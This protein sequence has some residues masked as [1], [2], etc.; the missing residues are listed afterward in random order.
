M[1][2]IIVSRFLDELAKRVLIFDGAMGTMV[3]K[4]HALNL[5]SDFLGRE[6]CIDI[7]TKTRP[8]VLQSI[9]ESFLKA[10][11]DVVETNTFG[12]NKLVL[13]E[14]DLVQEVY[15]LNKQA[16]Q[17]AR[18]ACNRYLSTAKPRFVAGS[19]GPGTKMIS[20]G[21]TNWEN[22]HDS[23]LEQARGLIDGGCDLLIIETCQDLLQAKCAVSACLTALSEKSKTHNDIPIMVSITIETNGTMLLG[24]EI[25]AAV[26]ALHSYPIA[27]L[28]LNCA[29]G[30][31][32]MGEHLAYLAGNWDRNISVI[33]NAGLPTLE[34][35][36]TVYPLLPKPFA[37]TLLRFVNEY[38]VNIVGGCCGTTPEHINE[39]AKLI[40]N[41]TPVKIP[42]E[43][44]KPAISSLYSSIDLKQDTSFLIIGERSNANGSRIFKRLLEA[45][46]WDNLVS[47]GKQQIR[48]GSHML[49]VCVD[50]VGRDGVR[51]ITE[52]ISRYVLQVPVPLM[53]DSTDPAVIEAA[54]KLAGG[55]CLV[56]S[57]NL[58]DGEKRFNE[59]CP[60]LKKYGAGAVALTIDEDPQAGMA[61]TA[62][63]KLEIAQR[64]YNLYTQK[65]QLN[66]ADLLFDPLTFTIA[67]GNVADRRLAL[68]TLEGISSISQYYPECGIVLGVSNVSFGLKP[69][70]RNV[71]NSVFLTEALARGLTAAIVHASKILPRNKIPQNQWDAALN[72]IYDK[73]KTDY[74]PLK[75]FIKLFPDDADDEY[76]REKSA[77]KLDSLT[78]EQ[79]L[80]RHI[81][82]G[83][84]DSLSQ[85]LDAALKIYQP[86]EIIND[87]LLAGM[88]TVGELFGSGKMQLPFVLESAQVMKTAVAYLQPHMNKADQDKAKAKIILATVKGD[89]HDI[90]KNL[91]DIILTNNGY[92]VINLGI[93]QPIAVIINALNEHKAD[94]IGLSGLLVKSVNVM[95]N[96]LHELNARNINV[97][98]LLGGAALTRKYAENHLRQNYH[99]SL[100]YGKDAFEGLR[101]MNALANKTL[102]DIDNEINHRNEKLESLKSS[103]PVININNNNNNNLI[104]NSAA[105]TTAVVTSCAATAVCASGGN[106]STKY[107]NTSTVTNS[108]SPVP[109]PPFWGTELVTDL[110]L[111]EIY[112]YI[113]TI[114]LFRAQWGL[115]K[116]SQDK[117][118][119]QQILDEI[120]VPTFTRLQQELRDNNIL[121]PQLIY[122]YFPVQSQK[123]DLIIY[124][125]QNHNNE[126]ERFTFPRQNKG[127]HLCISDFFQSTES[128]K[129]DVLGMFICTMGS[130]VA[131]KARELFSSDEYTEYLYTHGM[132]VE[133]TEALAE[134][135]HKHMRKQLNI[136]NA[137]APEI[138]ELF[139][140]KYQ[141]A[142]YSFGYPACPN[143]QDQEILFKLLK[144]ERIGCSLTENWQIDPE[145]SVSAIV[146]HHPQAKYFNI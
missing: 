83:D 135:W 89:V 107:S 10:G 71:L 140:Q 69:A 94:A 20:L 110:S 53:I 121:Q 64:M 128:D 52:I 54:L 131:E 136:D 14:F 101:I 50:F 123:N 137:D 126:I 19:M 76:A 86:L 91:V 38:G 79:H 102:H 43:N 34:N 51:D 146:V 117:D 67:T 118:K 22:M 78:V 84:L 145:Q 21:H 31:N 114:A 48:D 47:I 116:G 111:N 142:R 39:L 42:I 60:L 23:Y 45:E 97:P 80:Q 130:Q 96:D 105:S 6:N 46:D 119:Y 18:A 88:K 25:E 112:K 73:S 30:P 77:R 49:D 17:I 115:K 81:I 74:D 87:H 124:D 15:T 5:D 27:C 9:H 40:D 4:Q 98:V 120:A 36:Q 28:G 59:I 11:A 33:P 63:R 44:G 127:K 55:K 108:D 95:E 82:E 7:I 122:G 125:P 13:Q 32:E 92:Q 109:Q 1:E 61:K 62:Q 113:N 8:D 24:T 100:Y 133:S 2:L 138:R 99:G 41:H 66:P 70:A 143:M 134:Y 104:N 35:G 129:M 57:I 68:E 85:H 103:K 16:A 93:K 72:L 132:G 37:E 144:P 26:T 139:K 106:E 141:G 3:Q 90:G 58:E 29:T 75:E 65:W 12:A 56:N